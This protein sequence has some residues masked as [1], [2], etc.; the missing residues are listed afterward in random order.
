MPAHVHL[1]AANVHAAVL[2]EPL[3]NLLSIAF[4]GMVN[5]HHKYAVQNII[6]HCGD[7]RDRWSAGTMCAQVRLNSEF[8]CLTTF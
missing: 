6:I 8:S 5:L 2:M 1:P 4:S 3:C 7:F